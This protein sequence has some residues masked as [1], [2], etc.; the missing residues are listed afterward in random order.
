ML[1]GLLKLSALQ[2]VFALHLV[3]QIM[4][5]LWTTYPEVLA[6][7]FVVLRNIDLILRPIWETFPFIITQVHNEEIKNKPWCQEWFKTFVPLEVVQE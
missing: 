3:I 7:A 2:V 1:L 6:Y 5:A 4:Y